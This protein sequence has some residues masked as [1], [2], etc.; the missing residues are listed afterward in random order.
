MALQHLLQFKNNKGP[1][2]FLVI[3]KRGSFQQHFGYWLRCIPSKQT[4]EAA[5]ALDRKILIFIL[6]IGLREHSISIFGTSE[7]PIKDRIF[8]PIRM[9]GIGLISSKETRKPANIGSILLFADLTVTL[10]PQIKEEAHNGRWPAFG[11]LTQAFDEAKSNP[12]L[13]LDLNTDQERDST[14]RMP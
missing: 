4:V 1:F 5:V 10:S 9:G 13:V 14:C 12:N 2:S 7:A 6:N 3:R 11:Q 8:F